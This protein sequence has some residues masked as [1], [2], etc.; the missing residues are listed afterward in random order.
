MRVR[1]PDLN[2]IGKTEFV[3]G[4]C[5]WLAVVIV[6]GPVVT[7]GA[8][9]VDEQYPAENA[10]ENCS[11]VTSEYRNPT[12]LPDEST[13][14]HPSKSA[15]G[16]Y[17]HIENTS[18]YTIEFEVPNSRTSGFSVGTVDDGRIVAS[19]GF[20]GDGARRQWDG[21][22]RSPSVT[23]AAVSQSEGRNFTHGERWLFG[24]A[25]DIQ[26]GNI[27][28]QPS[29]DGAI[30]EQY[31]YLGPVTVHRE[32]VGCQ[33][34]VYIRP[35]EA[36]TPAPAPDK[37][38]KM[39]TGAASRLDV[40]AANE[41]V[42]FFA[43]PVVPRGEHPAY[44][45]ANEFMVPAAY[46]LDRSPNGTTWIHEYVHTRQDYGSTGSFRWFREGSA[47]YLGA[48][49]HL[50]MG[51]STP[52]EYD[53]LLS[54]YRTV[55]NGT[56]LGR[57]GRTSKRSYLWGAA[58]LSRV[59]TNLTETNYSVGD[60]L[61]YSNRRSVMSAQRAEEW[62]N[63][64]PETAQESVDL[65]LQQ[66]VVSSDYPR[67]GYLLAPKWLPPWMRAMPLYLQPPVQFVMSGYLALLGVV[68]I[69]VDNDD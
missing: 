20:D 61:A 1:V 52:R 53:A 30:G 23:I 16:T 10:P 28:V 47:T 63:S 58:V 17:R 6:L 8:A 31:V 27:S 45:R 40:G 38:L 15:V 19:T 67:P 59:E 55:P 44:A 24:P 65:R 22:S 49:L 48:R 46:N 54:R 32:Q 33:E 57:A 9:A 21:D 42:R 60:L 7:P 2:E 4:V 62:A 26:G 51:Y 41:E 18:R 66:R 11:E 43:S 36:G 56:S 50:E 34:L 13:R 25:V 5:V 39:L 37:L 12:Y 14:T 69:F 3:G 68:T 35:A 29:N 64:G